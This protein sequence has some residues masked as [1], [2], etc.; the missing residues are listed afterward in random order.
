MSAPTF[1]TAGTNGE[2]LVHALQGDVS[3]ASLIA[4]ARAKFQ[5]AAVPAD[6]GAPPHAVLVGA[7]DDG[8]RPG[9]EDVLARLGLFDDEFRA[10]KRI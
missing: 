9:L 8:E 3:I 4:V 10:T 6:Q 7:P 1:A 2:L 5:K